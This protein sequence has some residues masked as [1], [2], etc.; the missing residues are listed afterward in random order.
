[1]AP[2]REGVCGIHS[3]VRVDTGTG[4]CAS[5]ILNDGNKKSEDRY[6]IALSRQ[7]YGY[8]YSGWDAPLYLH[9][10]A[11]ATYVLL[12]MIDWKDP[13]P[14]FRE[15]VPHD[16]GDPNARPEELKVNKQA[17]GLMGLLAL[18]QATH[19]KALLATIEVLWNS[20]MNDFMTKTL[21]AEWSV[22]RYSLAEGKQ[23]LRR[24]SI[25]PSM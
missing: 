17:Y 11:A 10:R 21:G 8:V 25:L 1:M 16:G 24:D 3:S 7:I 23:I 12:H 14:Y 13:L 22:E 2:V 19:D 20:F 15:K 9:A 18:Y 5:E 4:S 6:L